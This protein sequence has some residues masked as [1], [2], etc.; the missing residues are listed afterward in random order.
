MRIRADEI[1]V[2]SIDELRQRSP[3]Q[4]KDDLR[5]LRRHGVDLRFQ[6]VYGQVENTRSAGDTRRNIARVLT[7]L[8]EKQIQSFLLNDPEVQEGLSGGA[9]TLSAGKLDP[10]SA[11]SADDIAG[12]DARSVTLAMRLWASLRKKPAFFDRTRQLPKI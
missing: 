4:L 5:T 1:G 11:V 8:R 6:R 7:V 3:A 12:N 9:F 2:S 10:R